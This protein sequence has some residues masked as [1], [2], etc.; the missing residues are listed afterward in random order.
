MRWS[1]DG[2]CFIVRGLKRETRLWL[3]RRRLVS[4]ANGL[5]LESSARPK[6]RIVLRALDRHLVIGENLTWLREQG[7]IA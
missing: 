5:T 2:R 6:I 4:F 7:R 1:T 3:A